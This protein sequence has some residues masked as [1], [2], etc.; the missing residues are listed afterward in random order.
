[1]K[2]GVTLPIWFL[3]GDDERKNTDL[4]EDMYSTP[5]ACLE[6][7]KKLGVTSIELRGINDDTSADALRL[8]VEMILKNALHPTVHAWLPENLEMLFALVDEVDDAA[9]EY[10][11]R[12]A[13]PITVHGYSFGEL[14]SAEAAARKTVRGLRI[15]RT[16]LQKRKTDF[17]LALEICRDKGSGGVGQSFGSVYKMAAEVGFEGFG[18]CW[19]VG[20]SLSNNLFSGHELMPSADFVSRVVH[21]HIHQVGHN[22]RTHSYFSLDDGYIRE[23]IDVLKTAGYDGIYNLELYPGRWGKTAEDSRAKVEETITSLAE[24]LRA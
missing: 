12:Q 6:A 22:K 13:I 19:D 20:H 15:L 23:C 24:M 18:I 9:Q 4:W 2:I 14:I 5:K 3:T 7:L 1:M 16:Y 10:G 17:V 11:V 21:T 8:S